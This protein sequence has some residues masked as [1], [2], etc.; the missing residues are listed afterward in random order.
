MSNPGSTQ[1]PFPAPLRISGNLAADWKRFS[2]QWENYVEA[3]NLASESKKRRGAIFLASIGTDAYE[4]YQTFD[5]SSDDDSKDIDK[6]VEA[7]R[8]HCVV[9]TN[10]TYERY[11]FNRRS[12]EAGEPFDMFL[13]DLRRL[14]RTCNYTTLEDS[15]LRDRV[16]VGVRDDATRRK[17]LQT[18]KLDLKQA[19]DICKSS[20]AASKQLRDISNADDVHAVSKSDRQYARHD[21]RPS[22]RPPLRDRRNSPSSR[23]R[24]NSPP[25]RQRASTP[26]PRCMFCDRKHAPSRRA[27]A[28]YGKSCTSCGKKNHFASVCR[29][30]DKTVCELDADGRDDDIEGGEILALEGSRKGRLFARMQVGDRQ[31]RF[32]LDCG[33][34]VNLLPISLA[35]QLQP[36]G[37][38]IRPAESTLRMFDSC[39]LSTEGMATFTVTHP[40]NGQEEILDFYLA[41]THSQ[42]L[43]GVEACLLFELLSVNHDNICTLQSSTYT[44]LTHDDISSKY[45]DLFE[46]YG[47]LKGEVHLETDPTVAPVRMPLRKLPVAIKDQVQRELVSLESAGIITPVKEPSAWIS[48]LLVVKKPGPAG[49]VRLCVDPK[50]LNKALQRDH[51]PMPTI[52]DVL[53]TLTRAKVFSTVDAKNAFWHLELDEESSKLTTF[54]TPF[55]KFRWKRVPYGISVAPE[56]FQRRLHEALSGLKGIACIADDMLIYGCGDTMEEAQ[57]DHDANLLALL[58]RCRQQTIRLNKSKMRLHRPVVTYMGH[59]LTTS[60]IQP[61]KRKV[62]AIQQLPAPVDRPAVMRL[63]GMATY[64]A[65]YTPGFSEITAPIRQLLKREIE[66]HWDEN[67]HG[68]SL[69]KLKALLSSA[70]VLQY[71]D[72]NKD[73]VVQCDSSQSGLGAVLLQDGRPVEYAS[74]ALTA[75]EQA[76]AQIEKEL[77]AICFGMERLHTY[78]YGRHVTVETDHKPLIAIVKKALTTAPKRL[79][80]MLLRLQRYDFELVYRPG[81]RVIIADTLSR[82]YPPHSAEATAF[83]EELA[84]LVD[85]EQAEELR[86]VAS[87]ATILRIRTAGAQDEIY[88]LLKTQIKAG[89]PPNPNSVVAELREYYPFA[90]E[91]VISGDLIF[92]GQRLLVPA[93]ARADMLARIH[94]SHIGINGCI[95]RA[96]EA[97]FWPGM[98]G[99][100][101]AVVEQCSVCNAFQAALQREPLMSHAVPGRPWEK[102]GVDIFT[103]HEQ[104]YLITVDYLSGYFEVDRLPSKRVCDIIYILKTQFARHG[105]PDCVFSDNSPFGAHEFKQFAKLYEFTTANSSPNFSQSNG[106]TENAVKTC[107]RLMTKALEDKAD[108]FLALLDWRNTPSEQLKQSPVQL[109]FGRRTRTKLPAA[110][111][112]L[113][114]PDTEAAREALA[115]AKRK[116]ASYYNRGTKEKPTLPVGQTVRFKRRDNADWEKGAIKRVLPYRSYE[117]QL[118]DGTTRRRTSRHVRF[119]AEPPIVMNDVFP[120]ESPTVERHAMPQ[121]RTF[122]STLTGVPA[123]QSAQFTDQ[124]DTATENQHNQSPM[125]TAAKPGGRLR[126]ELETTQPPAGPS[127]TV[128]LPSRPSRV[129]TDRPP[130]RKHADQKDHPPPIETIR[131]TRSGR[132]VVTPER[133]REQ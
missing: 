67:I 38:K 51:Y 58:E 27:C 84:A 49:G 83:T 107:K 65:R 118:E 16:V 14:S 86:M 61:D 74:R 111:C 82:A 28:A 105:I 78:V 99:Q 46:G 55:G 127:D 23:D 21:S 87:E 128:D 34:T 8:N 13:A 66:F 109:L 26:G 42:P 52:D 133:Y 115:A 77:L 81:T 103:F 63:L 47:K 121:R 12:Q 11:V 20:E 29:S 97:L 18:R 39:A 24:R 19:I 94:S 113:R 3:A 59:E 80:R 92:K 22:A 119:S 101:K 85:E 40:I 91:L 53:P 44:P 72:L 76:Y 60:G 110:Q 114:T 130:G 129:S 126:C 88:D 95:R 68:E 117:V 104:N 124:R 33:A 106:K 2:G 31:V 131:T 64:L 35:K 102:V 25:E 37:L 125:V 96:R 57:R 56:L 93:E 17:L 30:R 32:L 1:I 43:L 5:F 6:I 90:D 7:F 120:E 45:A 62:E 69:K 108:P 100:I 73:V 48:A 71:Y 122:T 54:E 10:E 123:E 79:Q 9:E 75:T 36:N 4:L 15:I 112:L 41:T 70:P 132:R 98:T 89:W 116:Q 50:S